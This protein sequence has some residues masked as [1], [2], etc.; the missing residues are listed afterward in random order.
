MTR[1]LWVFAVSIL[2]SSP[3]SALVTQLQKDDCSV[4]CWKISGPISIDDVRVVTGVLERMRAANETPFFLLDSEGGDVEAAIGIGRLFRK[5][6]AHV[7]IQGRVA[8]CLSACVFIYAGATHR[9]GEKIGIHRPFSQTTKQ[10]TYDEIQERQRRLNAIAKAFLE[11]MNVSPRLLEA[12]NRVP[13]EQIR[14]LS[15][16]EMEEFGLGA[17]DPVQQELKDAENAR[18][19]GLSMQEFFRRKA[20]VETVCGL[21]FFAG[22]YFVPAYTSCRDGVMRGNK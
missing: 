9:N 18:E 11:E 2:L 1:R 15:S 10:R 16:A 5:M 6:S 12:M 17:V 19:Y 13:P 8:R 20:L 4:Y 7:F 14:M 3:V 22:P 21:P